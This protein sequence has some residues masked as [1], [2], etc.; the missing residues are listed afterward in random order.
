[1]KRIK[2]FIE[3]TTDYPVDVKIYSEH[4][5]GRGAFVQWHNG[6][7]NHY[8]VCPKCDNPA[9]VLGLF[10]KIEGNKKPHARHATYDV[11][12]IAPFN[13]EL[14]EWCENHRDH[15]DF[16]RE[17]RPGERTERDAHIYNTAHQY[18]DHAINLIERA[19]GIKV[20]HAYAEA[21][22]NNYVNR[23]VDMYRGACV[24][25]IPWMMIFSMPG[26]PLYGRQISKNSPI[27]DYISHNKD[28]QLEETG[29]PFWQRI[30]KTNSFLN[31]DMVITNYR[32]TVQDEETHSF[33]TISIGEVENNHGT[34]RELFG[35]EI[36]VSTRLFSWKIKKDTNKRNAALL[37]IA[38]KVF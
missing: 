14:Y 23:N 20:S 38:N 12:E 32:S 33:L 1:M 16:V 26:T 22:A 21:I 28:V 3:E 8:A 31:L 6:R 19:L 13:R 25:N 17:V 4:T 10:K 2:F 7:E 29:D 9:V 11:P 37:E 35:T 36:E 18:F 27:Y 24:D 34:F 5:H 15:P 30:G